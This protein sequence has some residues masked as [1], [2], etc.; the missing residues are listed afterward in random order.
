MSTYKSSLSCADR[1]RLATAAS[2]A[3]LGFLGF[4]FRQPLL[5]VG[6]TLQLG[7]LR[8]L[9]ARPCS[10]GRVSCHGLPLCLR[11]LE[12]GHDSLVVGLDDVLRDTFHA[13]DLDIETGSIRESI[14]D[15]G[16][17]FLVYLAHM[18]RQS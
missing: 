10:R 7:L 4:V 16:Q 2:R 15:G 12:L 13:E 9:S 17:L 18:H 1:R 8:R 3:S 6:Y 14:V 11:L 5:D